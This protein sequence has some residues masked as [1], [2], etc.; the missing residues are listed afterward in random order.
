MPGTRIIANELPGRLPPSVAP[1][2]Y[3]ASRSPRRQ[4]LLAQLGIDCRLLIDDDEARAE[5]LEQARPGEPPA[6][7]VGRVALAKAQAALERLAASALPRAPLLA[8]DTTVAIG[9]TLLGKPASREAAAGML[10]SLS[11]RTHRV[12]TAVV[13]ADA[14]GRRLHAVTQ[15][16]RVR[17]GRLKP[18]WI[19]DYVASGEPIGKA[20]GYAIQGLAAAF[21]R[22]IDG[23]HSGIMGLP[24]YETAELLRRVGYPART[25]S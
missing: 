18:A 23:S 2:I 21:V 9:G 6:R 12:L 25:V 15:I 4:A 16:S 5:A 1:M 8:A 17:F 10:R 19:D 24:L 20:G 3:L 11:G 22:R 13:V 7:Y 14:T